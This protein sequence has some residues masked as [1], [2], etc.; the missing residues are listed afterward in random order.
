MKT[1][2]V[3]KQDLLEAGLMDKEGTHSQLQNGYHGVKANFDI[4]V[5]GSVLFNEWVEQNVAKVEELSADR[6]VARFAIISVATGTNN[7]TLGVAEQMGRSAWPFLT[8]KTGTNPRPSLN[9]YSVERIR[10]FKPDLTIVLEDVG[11][12]GFTCSTV[13]GQLIDMGHRPEVVITW[14]R[15]E[16]M[17]FLNNQGVNYHP[18]IYHP[19]A[20]YTPEECHDHGY[21]AQGWSLTQN[22]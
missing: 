20:D 6:K 8:E 10:I 18:I 17:D 12:T 3:F 22:L 16:K 9:K 11:K 14:Q 2:E 19:L 21:C 15:R 5:P 7:L 4:L 1:P 13:T